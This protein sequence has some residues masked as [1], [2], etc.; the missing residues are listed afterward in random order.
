MHLI[1]NQNNVVL[2]AGGTSVT[3]AKKKKY[4]LTQRKNSKHGGECLKKNKQI[5]MSAKC[6][7]GLLFFLFSLTRYR[8]YGT[9][10][11]SKLP[12]V[13]QLHHQLQYNTDGLELAGYVQ[14]TWQTDVDVGNVAWSWSKHY[15]LQHRQ[16]RKVV[17]IRGKMNN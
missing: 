14:P 17:E 13:R 8:R 15:S 2:Y 1:N 6:G 9:D 12:T 5:F 7:S 16:T 10:G 4:L 11:W 3:G